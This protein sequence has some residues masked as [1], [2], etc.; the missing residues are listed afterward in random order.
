MTR[1]LYYLRK[2]QKSLAPVFPLLSTAA[3][4]PPPLATNAFRRPRKR[5]LRHRFLAHLC[6]RSHE[7]HAELAISS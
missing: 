6:D 2:K 1:R 5:R 4:L 3:T 7:A